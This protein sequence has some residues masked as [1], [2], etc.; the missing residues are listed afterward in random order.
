MRR[1]DRASG[2]LHILSP[3]PLPLASAC[4][5]LVSWAGAHDVPAPL[6]YRAAAGEG[7]PFCFRPGDIVSSKLG[8]GNKDGTLRKNLKRAR[9]AR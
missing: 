2:V 4:D 1:Y 9:L 8:K 6:L 5:V 3:L 7:D